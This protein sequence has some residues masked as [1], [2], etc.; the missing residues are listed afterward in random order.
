MLKA[1][2]TISQEFSLERLTSLWALDRPGVFWRHDVDHVLVCAVLM[3]TWEQEFG[4]RATYY[5]R[6]EEYDCESRAFRWA[7]EQILACGHELG[8]HVDPGVPREAVVSDER[9]VVAC[10]SQASKLARWP[11]GNRISLHRPGPDLLWREIEGYEH[12]LGPQWQGRYVSDSRNRF[13]SDPEALLRAT[14]PIQVNLHP[15]W[16][17]L[18]TPEA[19]R[20]REQHEALV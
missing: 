11:V 16:W 3:A 18:S 17:F 13:R 4:I 2:S 9:L 15:C 5:L 6:T 1:R 20:L 7:V 14:E 8:T 19:K 12:A 10:E